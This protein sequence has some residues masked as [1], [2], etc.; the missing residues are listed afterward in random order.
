MISGIVNYAYEEARKEKNVEDLKR[1][2]IMAE[3]NLKAVG[4][5]P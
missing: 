5:N 3:G 2:K 1:C 4:I